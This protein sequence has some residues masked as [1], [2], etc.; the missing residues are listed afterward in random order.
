MPPVL[1]IYGWRLFFY[2]NESKEPIHIHAVKAD[3]ECK[4]WILVDD[5]EIVEAFSYNL[6]PT[7]KKEIKKII[8]AHF[9][10]IVDAWYKYFN[11]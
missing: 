5:V 3:M 6:T 8:Y 10:T 1:Y 11:T 2:S 4:F 9:D 7:S